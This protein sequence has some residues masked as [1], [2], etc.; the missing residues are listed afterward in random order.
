MA[1]KTN[2]TNTKTSAREPAGTVP[3]LPDM[4]GEAGFKSPG[5]ASAVERKLD[6]IIEL[7]EAIAGS[8]KNIP[9]QGLNMHWL[10][11][12]GEG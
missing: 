8:T 6:R 9:F 5:E 7:L 3:D 4:Q 11:G 1:K 2:T 12:R 10:E